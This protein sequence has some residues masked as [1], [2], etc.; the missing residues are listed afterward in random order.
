[1]TKRDKRP[2]KLRQNPSNVSFDEL[3][4]VLEAAGFALDHVTGSH[5]VFRIQSGVQVLKV[6]IPFSRP[7]KP[8]YVRQVLAAIDQ[9]KSEEEEEVDDDEN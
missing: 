8:I 3:R 5:H 6:V 9:L 4:Q 1:M 2:Q 7:V